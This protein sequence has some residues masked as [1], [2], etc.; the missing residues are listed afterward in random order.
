MKT[1][2]LLGLSWFAKVTCAIGPLLLATTAGVAYADPTPPYPPPSPG[3]QYSLGSYLEDRF[4]DQFATC[5][6]GTRYLIAH[7]PGSLGGWLPGHDAPVSA[8]PT[9]LLNAG[10]DLNERVVAAF[11]QSIARLFAY[12][13]SRT[14]VK[15]ASDTDLRSYLDMNYLQDPKTMLPN[16]LDS[17]IYS[18]SC[19][20]TVAAAF[21]MDA[22][23]GWPIGT[24]RSALQGDVSNDLSGQLGIVFGKFRS[25]LS[26]MYSGPDPT[27]QTY[28][29]LVLWE[30]YNSNHKKAGN[31]SPGYLLTQFDGVSAYHVFTKGTSANGLFKLSTASSI[32]IA[33]ID[34]SAQTQ[35]QAKESLRIE[36]F[37][38]AVTGADPTREFVE[39][40]SAADLSRAGVDNKAQLVVNST[41][42]KLLGSGMLH[43]QTLA[44][45]PV[46]WCNSAHWHIINHQRSRIGDLFLVPGGTHPLMATGSVDGAAANLPTCVFQIKYNNTTAATSVTLHYSLAS[47]LGANADLNDDSGP[48]PDDAIVVQAQD[49]RLSADGAPFIQPISYPAGYS[50]QQRTVNGLSF[51]DLTWSLTYKVT[52]DS[53]ARISALAPRA[54]TVQADCPSNGTIK[55]QVA[56]SSYDPSNSQLTLAL[57]YT[58][59]DAHGALEYTGNAGACQLSGVISFTL[60]TGEVVPKVLPP[61]TVLFPSPSRPQLVALPTHP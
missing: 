48:A 53:S 40:P 50:T 10:I 37:G 29:T 1:N 35:Y 3:Q 55:L 57:A 33:S 13:Y 41:D 58:V 54:Q 21:K 30:W 47:S 2:M 5:T 42:G 31:H 49:V 61:T 24:I 32:A 11:S 38:S 18:Y 15:G 20:A 51:H 22:G 39:M 14:S 7:V 59:D 17:V 56:D 43:Q 28:A 4:E 19:S 26:A 25:P 34:A 16:G 9:P 36:N 44:G 6:Q 60:A 27:E 46:Q 23:Y 52:E 45:V 8:I 12:V